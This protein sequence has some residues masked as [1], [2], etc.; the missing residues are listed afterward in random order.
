MDYKSFVRSNAALCAAGSVVSAVMMAVSLFK[1]SL[2]GTS[3]VLPLTAGTALSSFR[4]CYLILTGDID[5][6]ELEN[7]KSEDKLTY[8]LYIAAFIAACVTLVLYV[9]KMIN[10]HGGKQKEEE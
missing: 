3:C 6:E 5:R 9:I 8:S 7:A 1:P 2:N 10:A 4:T